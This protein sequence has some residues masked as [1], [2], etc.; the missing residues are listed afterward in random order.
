MYR[1]T[2]AFAKPVVF[3]HGDT[4]IGRIDQPVGAP[5]NFTRVETF[6]EA[7]TEHWMHVKVDANTPAVFEITARKAPKPAAETEPDEDPDA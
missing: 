6:A 2:A 7:D 1:L 5:A 4:H 3:V